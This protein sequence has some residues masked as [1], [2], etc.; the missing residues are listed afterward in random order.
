MN[1][2]RQA[3]EPPTAGERLTEVTPQRRG[4]MVG[5]YPPAKHGKAIIPNSLGAKWS[6]DDFR[7][8]SLG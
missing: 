3:P 7:S 1:R 8:R 5:L 6:F 4:A 2:K